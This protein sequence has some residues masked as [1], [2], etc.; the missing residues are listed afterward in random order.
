MKKY[1]I[2]G[3]VSVLVLASIVAVRM[4]LRVCQLEKNVE[5]L[6]NNARDA[7]ERKAFDKRRLLGAGL[8]G[9]RDN[10]YRQHLVIWKR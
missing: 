8:R 5:T 1:K 9:V 10:R 2:I 4:T 7:M 3:L 6:L